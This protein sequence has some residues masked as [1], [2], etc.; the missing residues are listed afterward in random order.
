MLPMYPAPPVISIFNS[1]PYVYFLKIYKFICYELDPQR[2][3]KYFISFYYVR[4][5]FFDYVE[6]F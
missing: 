2:Y 6:L 4:L 1:N 5:V 3:F